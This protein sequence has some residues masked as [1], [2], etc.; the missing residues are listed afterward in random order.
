M[1]MRGC[2]APSPAVERLMKKTP[3]VR[4]LFILMLAVLSA[5]CSDPDPSGGNARLE[6]YAEAKKLLY[7]VVY[8]D[9]R[10]TFYCGASFDENR[11]VT[12]PQGMVIPEHAERAGRAETE[13]LVP[14]ENFGRFFREWREGSPRCTAN[15]R[16]FKGRRCAELASRQYRLMQADL[17]NLVPAVGAVNAMR[18][19]YHFEELPDVPATFGA[20][21]MKI[22][23][24]R[25]EPP[26]SAKGFAA[27]TA[28]Y[29]D[30]AY[31]GHFHLSGRQR[32]LFQAWDAK[33]PPDEWECERAKRIRRAQ[34]NANAFV[35]AACRRA[36]R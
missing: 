10:R 14:A 3:L 2:P 21:P 31:H 15:G 4:L 13:H 25:A 16:P 32:R 17:Y 8:A 19:N 34:G 11:A 12:L 9:H 33:F 26:D 5:A 1:R 23:G 24:R 20:C 29:M 36:G 7:R 22:A 30:A 27:R 6:S 28:L 35:E 18:R